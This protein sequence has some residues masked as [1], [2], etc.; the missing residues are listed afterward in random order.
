[1]LLISGSMNLAE[2]QSIEQL[3]TSSSDDEE[4]FDAPG[5][6]SNYTDKEHNYHLYT[7]I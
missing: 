7:H 5:R 1:M 2:C 4:F 6:L 3:Q